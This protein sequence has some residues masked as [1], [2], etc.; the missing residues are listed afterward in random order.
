MLAHAAVTGGGCEQGA[1]FGLA[2]F[3]S[4]LV[5]VDAACQPGRPE[6]EA[7]SPISVRGGAIRR[8]TLRRGGSPAEK[9]SYPTHRKSFEVHELL[10]LVYAAQSQDAKAIE[11]L[12][13]AV[14]L[15]PDSAAARTNLAA[16]LSRS[17]KPELA[18]EQFRKAL[19]LEPRRLTTPTTIWVSSI[20]SPER[21]RT[22]VRSSKRR[23]RSILPP[24]TTATILRRPISSPGDLAEAR[25]LSRAL[26]RQKN[27]GELHNLLGQI[28]E[29]D[30]KFVAAANEFET[31]AHMDPSEDNLFDWGSELLLHRTYEPAIEV[32]RQ[33][34]QRY[35]NSPRLQIG[36]GW[37]STRGANMR[38]RSR[39]CLRRRIL[40]L[41]T[42]AAI[43]F[44]PRPTSVLRTRR[45]C[46]PEIPALLPSLS[47]TTR[48]RSIIT[49]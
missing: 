33:A 4:L 47:R 48:W 6:P 7:G 36:L 30:G 11:H 40:I 24:T 3:C 18:G 21:S 22:H 16:S 45:R 41:P 13:A 29:K 46:D 20:F 31:A 32:F 23:S 39:P 12:E 5:C 37:R 49:R 14:R 28:E 42:L 38:M 1:G 2:I 9:I 8:R 44:S 10:G 35:P 27:T 17:G 19:A 43:C 15:K 26:M 25:H 34:T